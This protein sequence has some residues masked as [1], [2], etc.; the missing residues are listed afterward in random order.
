[1]MD[2]EIEP[3]FDAPRVE[4]LME[5]VH[6]DLA[7]EAAIRWCLPDFVVEVC[8][9]HHGPDSEPLLASSRLHRTCT[10]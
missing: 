5:T 9:D 10:S 3:I 6:I 7:C 1:M 4:Q 8:Q 2:G